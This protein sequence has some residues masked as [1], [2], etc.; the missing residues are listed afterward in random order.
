MRLKLKNAKVCQGIFI[1]QKANYN[2]VLIFR[3][4]AL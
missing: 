2:S 3:I 4:K 1:T